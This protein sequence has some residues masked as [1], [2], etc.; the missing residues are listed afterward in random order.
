MHE[1]YVYL[2]GITQI[3]DLEK[4]DVR[5]QKKIK[6]LKFCRSTIDWTHVFGHFVHGLVRVLVPQYGTQV[7]VGRERH[8]VLDPA[9]QKQRQDEEK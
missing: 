2:H 1:I 3:D 7:P 4:D 9:N 5:C 6:L 8:S